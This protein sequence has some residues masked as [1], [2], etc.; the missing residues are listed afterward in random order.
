VNS[1]GELVGDP[2]LAAVGPEKGRRYSW[3]FNRVEGR[4]GRKQR[5]DVRGN[6]IPVKSKDGAL[7]ARYDQVV[8]KCAH[9][10]EREPVVV[11]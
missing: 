7:L 10:V 3:S 9:F 2:N 1:I 11:R 5:R 8:S 6:S 4:I